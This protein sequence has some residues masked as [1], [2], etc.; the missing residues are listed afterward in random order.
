[1]L[2]DVCC[3]CN[4]FKIPEE[5]WKQIIV[6]LIECGYVKGFM[7]RRVKEGLIVTM[8]DSATITLS[9]VHFLEENGRMAK[10]KQFL[11]K[12]FEIALDIVLKG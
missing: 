3:D 7:Y 9:G 2:E 10:A 12:A 1:M 11:G 4:L 8:T 6:E 5:Y